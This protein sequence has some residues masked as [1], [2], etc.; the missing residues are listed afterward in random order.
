MVAGAAAVGYAEIA[1][2]GYRSPLLGAL[3][4]IGDARFVTMSL[5]ERRDV[6]RALRRFFHPPEA[7]RT[8]G[9]S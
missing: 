2:G 8:P 3:A 5:H 7:V 6:Y 4:E 9:E 1:E